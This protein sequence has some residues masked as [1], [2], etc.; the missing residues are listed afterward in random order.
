MTSSL[1]MDSLLL[2]SSSLVVT[3]SSVQVKSSW[4]VTISAKEVTISL[5]MKPLS[6][7][8]YLPEVTSL[9]SSRRYRDF[10]YNVLEFLKHFLS[11][12]FFYLN[13]GKIT[14]GPNKR[15]GQLESTLLVKSSKLI[16]QT[17]VNVGEVIT[18]MTI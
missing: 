11:Y 1:V 8:T 4:K 17:A 13:H 14:K 18:V 15:F 2:I 3:S 9:L 5:D 12:H 6:K 7:V 10:F 16:Y